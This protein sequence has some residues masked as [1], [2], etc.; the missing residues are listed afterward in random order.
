[1]LFHRLFALTGEE[2]WRARAER[3]ADWLAASAGAYPAGRC[4]GMLPLLWRRHGTKEIVCVLPDG[5]LP[6]SFETVRSRWAPEASLLLKTP[7]NAALLASVAPFTAPMEAKAGK[8]TWYVCEGGV[9]GLPVTEG[10][11]A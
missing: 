5:R 3:Q 1:M 4:F 8:A 6:A 7:E 2:N 10:G 9:C 11:E